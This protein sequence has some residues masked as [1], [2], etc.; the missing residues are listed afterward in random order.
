[1]ANYFGFAKELRNIDS[2]YF[3]FTIYYDHAKTIQI[4][5]CPNN[6]NINYFFQ[7]FPKRL[8]PHDYIYNKHSSSP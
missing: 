3:L 2:I 8:Y 7:S 1:M 4:S 5:P 6:P